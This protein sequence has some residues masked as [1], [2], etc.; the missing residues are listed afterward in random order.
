MGLFR[1]ADLTTGS[2]NSG[3]ALGDFSGY[4]LTFVAEE[5]LPAPFTDIAAASSIVSDCFTGAT[6]VTA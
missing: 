5:K 2:I 6:I 3:G 1:G 4:S